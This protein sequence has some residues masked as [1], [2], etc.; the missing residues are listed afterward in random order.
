MTLL[1]VRVEGSKEILLNPGVSHTMSDGD[2]CFYIGE[3]KEEH[4]EFVREEP[5]KIQGGLWST[6]AMVASLALQISGL[7]PEQ[8]IRHEFT[9]GG[10][11]KFAT[12]HMST[13]VN[14]L[15][16]DSHVNISIEESELDQQLRAER[17]NFEHEAERGLKLLEFHCDREHH[18]N[19]R[20]TVKLNIVPKLSRHPYSTEGVKDGKK[21]V[22]E[23]DS[24]EYHLNRDNPVIQLESI[25]LELFEHHKHQKRQSKSSM[26]SDSHRGSLLKR[27]VSHFNPTHHSTGDNSKFKRFRSMSPAPGDMCIFN[28]T[29]NI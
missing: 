17:V 7:R 26:H 8:L 6:S 4:H 9:V 12:E 14:S 3:S 18:H 28:H 15:S 16:C 20:P 10:S 22:T 21:L 25:D 11:S 24:N 23:E 13:N 2:T 19:S 29:C 5:S 27:S 1:G